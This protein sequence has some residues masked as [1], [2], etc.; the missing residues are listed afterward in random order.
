[1]NNVEKNN[2][3][4]DCYYYYYYYYL[5]PSVVKVPEG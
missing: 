2:P 5:M 4:L 3:S 1:M